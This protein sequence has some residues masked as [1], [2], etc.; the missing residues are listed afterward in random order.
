[1]TD[2]NDGWDI[3]TNLGATALAVAAQ[4]AAE[5]AQPNPLVRDEF[6][7]ILID[8][9]NEPGWQAMAKGDLAWMGPDDDVGRRTARAGRDYVAARTVFFDEFCAVATASG[10]R[11]VVI[12]AAGLDARAYRLACLSGVEVFE[13]DQPAVQAFKDSTLRAH[14]ATPTANVHPVAVDLRDARWPEMLAGAGWVES[15]PS[16]WLVEGLLP[17]LSSAEHDRLFGVV[18]GL[19]APGSR[20]AAEVYHHSTRHFG[21][22][23]LG[24]WRDGAAGIGQALDIDVDVTAFI[25]HDD[26]S[27][28]ASWLTQHGWA[29]ESLDSR[30]EMTRLGRPVPPDL[31]EIAPASSLV[32]GVLP[33][34]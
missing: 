2:N 22:Q 4:R 25:Q 11:Q 21:D 24:K 6:A 7:A 29:V 8:A 10:I 20:L 18:T 9:V 32:T 23:R 15:A 28:T 16:A 14:G 34:P 3:T 19:S 31:I 33:L 12:L 26:A 27:D 30:D 13:I 5:T 1:M 17:Y